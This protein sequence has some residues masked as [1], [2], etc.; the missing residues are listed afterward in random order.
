MTGGAKTPKGRGRHDSK[1]GNES[2]IQ[3]LLAEMNDKLQN[4][5]TKDDLRNLDKSIRKEISHNT[6]QIRDLDQVVTT[7]RR[8]LPDKIRE[9]VVKTVEQLKVGPAKLNSKEEIA[10]YHACRRSIRM[11]PVKQ[12]D[13]GIITAIKCFMRDML[14][15]EP[16]EVIKIAVEATKEI[17]NTPRTKI[18]DEV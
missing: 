11:W 18:H 3:N 12:D 8:E 9:E 2:S 6:S 1:E 13:K 10:D 17:A 4:M 15:M 7:Q 5:P 14:G 16:R